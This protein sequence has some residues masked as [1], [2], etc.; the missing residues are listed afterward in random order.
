MTL[1]QNIVS[2]THTPSVLVALGIVWLLPILIYLVV[3]LVVKGKSGTIMIK[4]PNYW[5]FFW[6]WGLIQLLLILL[7][8]VFP[9]WTTIIE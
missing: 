8:L 5:H 9:I 1:Y 4:R 2:I 6:I 7:L 3:G